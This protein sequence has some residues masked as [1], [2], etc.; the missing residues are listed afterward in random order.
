[1]VFEDRRL[2]NVHL[3][4]I[5]EETCLVSLDT[6][7]DDEGRA[8]DVDDD[9]LAPADGYNFITDVFFLTQKTLDLGFRVVQEKFVKLNQELN[10]QQNAF[11]EAQGQDPQVLL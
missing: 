3:P 5:S 9:A 10:R 4:G 8:M 1:M 11:R 7:D 2:K 6:D